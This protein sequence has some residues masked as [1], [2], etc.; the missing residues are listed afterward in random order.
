M[1]PWL[2]VRGRLHHQDIAWLVGRSADLS[3]HVMV[4][5][6]LAEPLAFRHPPGAVNVVVFRP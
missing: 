6:K 1:V 5:G 3:F 4:R 2:P